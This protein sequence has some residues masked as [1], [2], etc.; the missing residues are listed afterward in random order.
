MPPRED[1]KNYIIVALASA[2][3]GGGTGSWVSTAPA[4]TPA[5]LSQAMSESP[6]VRERPL[7][8][9]RIEQLEKSQEATRQLLE[10]I[11]RDIRRI[12]NKVGQ[13]VGNALRD[14]E[15]STEFGG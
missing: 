11:R 8:N 3:I 15:N 13:E 14:S 4:V 1:L 9:L 2:T 5:Q 6:W 7:Y 10:E 12:A